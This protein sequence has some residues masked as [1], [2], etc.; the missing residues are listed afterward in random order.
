MSSYL[1]SG[2]QA[3][4]QTARPVHIASGVKILGGEDELDFACDGVI[5]LAWQR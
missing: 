3:S 1:S 4:S 2:Q 5:L